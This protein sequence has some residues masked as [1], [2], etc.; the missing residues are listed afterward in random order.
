MFIEL[1]RATTGNTVIVNTEMIESIARIK[2]CDKT[3]ITLHYHSIEVKEDVYEIM[4]I[5][6]RKNK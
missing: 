5:I 2:H 3:A 4:S 1:T 6:A